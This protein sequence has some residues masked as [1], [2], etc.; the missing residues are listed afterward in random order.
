M[1][2]LCDTLGEQQVFTGDP[3]RQVTP[4][5]FEYRGSGREYYR[6][7]RD[8]FELTNVYG[9]LSAA[10]QA[11]LHARVLALSSCHGAAACWSAGAPR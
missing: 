2:S 1:W 5:S 6:I 11:Q 10:E 8:P 9:Q 3:A 7:D 4:G